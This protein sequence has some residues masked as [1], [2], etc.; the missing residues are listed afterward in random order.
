M[1]LKRLVELGGRNTGPPHH[2]ERQCHFQLDLDAEG[3]LASTTLQELIAPDAKGRPR[4]VVHTVPTTVRTVGVAPNL[5]VDDAQYVLG[6]TDETSRPDRVHQCHQAFIDLHRR[7]AASPE[8]QDDPIAQAVATFLSSDAVDRVER[9]D[10]CT[11]KSVVLIAVDGAPAF[12]SASVSAFWNTEVAHRKG[13]STGEGLCLVCGC[14]GPL[15]D[16][17]PGKVPARLV[18]GASNDAALISVNERAF[19]YGLIT[20][21]SASP[22]CMAC[23][24][25]VTSGLMQA[26]GPDHSSTHGGQDSRLAWWTTEPTSL[27]PMAMLRQPSDADV[28][29]LLGSVHDGRVRAEVDTARFCALTVG[30]NVARIMVRDWIDMPV[31][32]VQDNVAGWFADHRMMSTRDGGRQYHGVA[33]LA[34][35]TGRWIRGRNQ[36]SGRYAEFGMKGA[37]RPDGVHRDLVR[38]A[39]RKTPPPPSLLAHIVHRIRTDGRIDDARAALLR[40]IL[41]RRPSTTEK[42][43]TGLDRSNTNP[44]YVAGRAFVVLEQIQYDV[45]EGKVNTTYGDR[46]FAGAIS[47]PRAALVN[48][49]RDAAAWLR[50]LRRNPK[51]QGAVVRH[52]QALDELFDLVNPSRD[53]PSRTTLT[54]QSLFLLGYHHQRADRFTAIRAAKAARSENAELETTEENDQ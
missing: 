50:K 52:Q 27:D 46:F 26:L 7:W 43:M 20:Q 19:G 30:G 15:L 39:L 10:N 23:G 16:T 44:A 48:G 6:W 5:A 13:S 53:I 9:P 2:R 36:E 34:L 45:T 3:R 21:L 24:E 28:A 29:A 17:L 54:E 22:V 11:A 41:T 51:K 42:P 18:P 40:L 12:E 25:A 31:E 35:V 1:L 49:Q 38:A 33:Q 8:A 4:P 37:D 14:L 32:Q 47:N